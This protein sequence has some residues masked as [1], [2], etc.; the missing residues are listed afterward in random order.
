MLGGS[1][2]VNPGERIEGYFRTGDLGRIHA[3]GRVEITGR[4][5]AQFDVA[6]LKVNPTEVESV[7]GSYPGVQ[8]IAVV[9]LALSETV[10]RVRAVVVPEQG[11]TDSLR[12]GLLDYAEKFL[13]PHLR[14]RIIDFQESLPRTSSGKILR[15]QL[16]ESCVDPG[17]NHSGRSTNV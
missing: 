10:T 7:L 3:D 8:E 4:L 17:S 13:A 11:S 15:N 16:I 12:E 9:P 14:P 6:G 5:K 1:N 2:Q